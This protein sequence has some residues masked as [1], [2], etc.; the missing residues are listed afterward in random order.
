MKN[1]RRFGV[2]RGQ[3]STIYLGCVNF[4]AGVLHSLAFWGLGLTISCGI[5]HVIVSKFHRWLTHLLGVPRDLDANRTP[6]GLTGFLE[7]LFFTIA[8]AVNASDAL[9]AMMAWLA[10]K[11]AANWQS[12]TDIP[13]AE[14]KK[15]YTFSAIVT[16][17]LS[18][19]FAYI[20][21]LVICHHG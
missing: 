16:G 6:P 20:G 18:M 21:G 13:G 10:L 11:L 8:V 4:G 3:H 5:G 7:R 12:R 14:I 17:L 2:K 1:S 15:N 19:L 9:T